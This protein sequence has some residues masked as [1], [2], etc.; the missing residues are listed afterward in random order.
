MAASPAP[1]ETPPIV[2][3]SAEYDINN[4][5]MLQLMLRTA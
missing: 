4:R 1:L 5:S 3:F 2:Q